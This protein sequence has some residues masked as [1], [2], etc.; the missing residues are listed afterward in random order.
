MEWRYRSVKC[1]NCQ[2]IA[3]RTFGTG[4][5]KYGSPIRSCPHCHS[6]YYDSF[7][8]EKGIALFNDTGGTIGIVAIVWVLLSNSLV[9]VFLYLSIIDGAL[10]VFLLPLVVFVLIALLFDIGL[11]R[12]IKNHAHQ[13]EYHQRQIAYIESA[14]SSD[15]ELNLSMKRLS[16]RAYLD[17][18]KAC[19]CN[20]PNYFYQR[21]ER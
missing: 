21:L 15:P 14:D 16:N 1:P 4:K 10:D 17:A 5:Y 6:A 9:A 20:V 7:Y 12:S 18:L 19:G 2:S 11:I 8:V 13:E 3:E